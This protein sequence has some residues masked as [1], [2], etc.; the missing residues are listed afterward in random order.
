MLPRYHV[1]LLS[2]LLCSVI[3]VSSGNEGT[4]GTDMDIDSDPTVPEDE[5]GDS[6]SEIEGIPGASYGGFGRCY[7]C[8]K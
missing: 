2:H 5:D 4:E 1:P 8:S 6:D 3:T 7:R